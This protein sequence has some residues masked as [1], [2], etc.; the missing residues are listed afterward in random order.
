MNVPVLARTLEKVGLSTLVV[1]MMPLWADRIGVPRALGV[2]F[3]YGHTLGE[4]F[5]VDQQTLVLQEALELF[6][7]AKAPGMVIDSKVEWRLP[8]E[9]SIQTWQPNEASPIVNIL[10]SKIREM[11][12]SRRKALDS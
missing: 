7:K 5:N 3:P 9:E 12:R 8:L 4:S 1:T 10:S 6:T 11:V 2:E